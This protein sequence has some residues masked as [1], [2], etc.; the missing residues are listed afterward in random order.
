MRETQCLIWQKGTRMIGG[1]PYFWK[2]KYV[3]Y[4]YFT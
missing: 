2:V 3:C 1:V 4:T